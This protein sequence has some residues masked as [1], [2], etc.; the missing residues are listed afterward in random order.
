MSYRTCESF[1]FSV[2]LSTT[3][4][5]SM[6]LLQVFIGYVAYEL[7]ATYELHDLFEFCELE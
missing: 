4:D 1:A 2:E 7:D 3:F 6:G 5:L